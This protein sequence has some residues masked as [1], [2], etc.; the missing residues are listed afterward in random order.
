MLLSPEY[1]LPAICA[2][3]IPARYQRT[4][5]LVFFATPHGG[6]LTKNQLIHE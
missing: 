2:G 6:A 1:C 5:I 4:Q 3:N